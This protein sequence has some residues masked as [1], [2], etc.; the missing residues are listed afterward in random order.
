MDVFV[1]FLYK[2]SISSLCLCVSPLDYCHSFTLIFVCGK[3]SYQTQPTLQQYCSGRIHRNRWGLLPKFGILWS[4]S[5]IESSKVFGL[6]ILRSSFPSPIRI[7]AKISSTR[8]ASYLFFFSYNFFFHSYLL[9]L[10]LHSHILQIDC[11]F[12]TFLVSNMIIEKLQKVATIHVDAFF[13]AKWLWWWNSPAKVKIEN[14]FP[15]TIPLREKVLD[16][17]LNK[18]S[19]WA[20]VYLQVLFFLNCFFYSL[21]FLIVR[22]S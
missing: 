10:F 8:C 17:W 6:E 22:L 21:P 3:E 11:H 7:M 1:K 14:K 9:N 16:D 4:K 5:K 12:S 19:L 18:A 20:H 15:S 13:K 2:V